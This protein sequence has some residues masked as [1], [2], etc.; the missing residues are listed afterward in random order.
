MGRQAQESVLQTV[1]SHAWNSRMFSAH[2]HK[3]LLLLRD[4]LHMAK[5]ATIPFDVSIVLVIKLCC[6]NFWAD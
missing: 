6:Q 3:P 4:E 1:S 2:R 5:T